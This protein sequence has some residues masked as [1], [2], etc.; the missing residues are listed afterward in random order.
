MSTISHARAGTVKERTPSRNPL[1][2]LRKEMD[3]VLS[4]FWSGDLETWPTGV[5]IPSVDLIEADNALELRIDLPGMESKDITVEVSGNTVKLSGERKEEKEEKG[6]TYH[7]LERRSGS[8]LRT[9]T[10]PCKVNE[11]EAAAEFVNGVLTVKL[12]KSEETKAKRIS[13]KGG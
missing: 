12:P 9:I 10:L 8:F 13:V 2:L 6:K 1:A 7:R 11:D 3:D 4:R 5:D